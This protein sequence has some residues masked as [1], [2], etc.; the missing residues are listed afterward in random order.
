MEGG[1]R[2]VTQRR[3]DAETKAV[4]HWRTYLKLD[5]HSHWANIARREL[6]KL[7]EA[8]VVPGVGSQLK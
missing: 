4:R 3:A 7:R 2:N 5:P 1:R 6:S 8:A